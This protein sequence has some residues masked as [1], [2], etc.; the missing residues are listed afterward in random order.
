MSNRSSISRILIIVL[1]VLAIGGW[2]LSSLPKSKP[3]AKN[4]EVTSAAKPDLAFKK[5]G[6][7][8]I[9][10]MGGDSVTTIDIE[11][12]DTPEER[13]QGMMFRQELGGLQGMFFVFDEME[14]QSFWMKNTYI[15][16]D[17]IFI[18]DQYRIMD[19]YM[20]AEPRSTKTI[21]SRRPAKY[22]LEVN[23]GF[24]RAYNT[25]PGMQIKVNLDEGVERPAEM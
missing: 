17:I 1:L 2:I 9:Y 23:A 16:L 8:E 6:T 10:T 11:L 19:Q 15:P 7:L 3:A 22:V 21:V 25:G 18:S 24:C 14:P 20:G 13:A 4:I 12:A 5:E